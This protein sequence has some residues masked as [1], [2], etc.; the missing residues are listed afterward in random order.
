MTVIFLLKDILSLRKCILFSCCESQKYWPASF[1]LIFV[2]LVWLSPGPEM[3]L[4][5][6]S[7]PERG[8]PSLSQMCSGT[9]FLA[10]VINAEMLLISRKS[11]GPW[12]TRTRSGVPE[13]PGRKERHQHPID[14]SGKFPFISLASKKKESPS[15]TQELELSSMGAIVWAVRPRDYNKAMEIDCL[16]GSQWVH[17]PHHRKQ[18]V[19]FSTVPAD[20]IGWTSTDASLKIFY[21]RGECVSVESFVNNDDIK[22]IVK[23]LQV[24]VFLPLP[25]HQAFHAGESQVIEARPV[26]LLGPLKTPFHGG[27]EP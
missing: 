11:S 6:T 27:K 18:R 23:R 7:H 9:S 26:L 24:S 15:H 19:W 13:R 25:F 21:E 17:R 4:L 12:R 14:S 16:P 2:S 5:S 10:K 8:L 20:V 3:C 1:S 22:E